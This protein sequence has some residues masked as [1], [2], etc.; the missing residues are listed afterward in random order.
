M[1]IYINPA[2]EWKLR[3]YSKNQQ[4]PMAQVLGSALEKYLNRDIPKTETKS[5]SDKQDKF[6]QLHK[7]MDT[8]T[9]P[10]KPVQPP[11][12]DLPEEPS[13]EPIWD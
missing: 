12:G 1:N 6:N 10:V 5:L 8:R 7:A 9:S 3:E 4:V 13:V 2:L 11:G